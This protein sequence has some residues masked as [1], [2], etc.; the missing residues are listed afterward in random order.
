MNRIIVLANQKGGVGK[1]TSTL[2]IGA[3][4]CLLKRKVLLVDLDPQANL[5]YSL[6]IKAYELNKTIYNLLRG[7]ANIE[8]IITKHNNNDII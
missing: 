6:G 7:E 5:T 8:D 2:N 1:T 3:G 4:L